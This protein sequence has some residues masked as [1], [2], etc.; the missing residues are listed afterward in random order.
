MMSCCRRSC[1]IQ[2]DNS[3]VYIRPAI[4]TYQLLDYDKFEEIV[5]KG[6]AAAVKKL[7]VR[8]L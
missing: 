5:S 4:E 1:H 6:R 3:I 2:D 7:K 8:C